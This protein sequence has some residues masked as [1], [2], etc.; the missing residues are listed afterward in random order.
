MDYLERGKTPLKTFVSSQ[1][2]L[3]VRELVTKCGGRYV[4]F[5][6][7]ADLG[8]KN[9][10]VKELMVQ[11]DKIEELKEYTIPLETPDSWISKSL[12]LVAEGI[13]KRMPR[14]I[15]KKIFKY[16]LRAGACVTLVA[17]I[18]CSIAHTVLAS[19]L[20]CSLSLSDLI[21]NTNISDDLISPY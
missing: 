14:S 4:G 20:H 2:D 19:N 21:D 16:I 7:N 3:K 10:Q 11:I 1:T 6:N 15:K 12:T 9:A 5:N 17:I 18:Y 8:V 13:T